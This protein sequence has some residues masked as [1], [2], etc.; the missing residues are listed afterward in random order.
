MVC[1]GA[2][3]KKTGEKSPILALRPVVAGLQKCN[4]DVTCSQRLAMKSGMGCSSN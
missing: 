4:Q 2:V 3:Q 1:W